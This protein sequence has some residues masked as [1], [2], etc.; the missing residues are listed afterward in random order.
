VGEEGPADHQH[1]HADRVKPV[2]QRKEVSKMGRRALVMFMVL[3]WMAFPVVVRIAEAQKIPTIAVMLPNGGDPYFQA[4]WYGYE[5]EA[6]RLKVN[7]IF[8]DAGGYANVNKQI[9]QIEDVIQRK[10]DGIIFT[11]T[12]ST[13]TIPAIEKAIKAGIHVLNDNVICRT[14]M[15]KARVMKN[16]YE[17]GMLQATGLIE[18]LGGKGKVV[19]LP[20]H[21]G[22]DVAIDR[23]NG[24][25]DTFKRFKGIQ[26][27]DVK[28]TESSSAPAMKVMEDILQ[29]HPDLN[30]V[31]TFAGMVMQGAVQAIKAAG[32]KP[33]KI[34]VGSAD[35]VDYQKRF[36]EEGWV[37]VLVPNTPVQMAKDAVRLCLDMIQ[38]KPV[39]PMT[40]NRAVLV[41]PKT[42]PYYNW[43]DNAA[44]EGWKPSMSVS[45]K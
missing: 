42:L 29:A 36:M 41:T 39:P 19:M 32:I 13:A 10:V 11:A 7:L 3:S 5:M 44:P 17:I 38:K 16:D 4:K 28:W 8:Y 43:G 9:S 35:M 24:G 6:K 22:A 45:A 26:I 31:H 2:G 23:K 34:F 15:I 1:G 25:E 37:Q 18:L 12:S 21:A 30:A 40:W 33:G 14:D 20:G 27:V